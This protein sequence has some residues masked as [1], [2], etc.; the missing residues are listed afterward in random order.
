MSDLRSW[1]CRRPLRVHLQED[2]VLFFVHVP[3]T[4]GM[5]LISILESHFEPRHIFP[6]HSYVTEKQFLGYS[7]EQR[8]GYRLVR[9]HLRAGSY[10]SVFR[11][12]CQN[13]ICLTLLRDPVE[14][15]ISSYR[16]IVRHPRNPY[17]DEVTSRNL[18]LREYVEQFSSR[19]CNMQ[20][21]MIAGA[22][23]GNIELG[24]P[25]YGE[26][27]ALEI[28]VQRLEQFAFVGLTS[29]F[30]ESVELMCHTFGWTR[31]TEIPF[32][33][34]APEPTECGSVP[35]DVQ[36]IIRA[37]TELDRRL[38]EHAERLFERRCAQMMEERRADDGRH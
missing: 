16:H 1:T 28:A 34:A 32:E 21:W 29:W 12:I 15:T 37:K 20:T 14:R 30:V 23:T 33:N 8:A 19:V 38:L 26:E 36:E 27:A 25:A 3:K 5:S 22:V 31:P 6:G 2:D 11:H 7:P 24:A 9:M 4:G 10:G 17:H 13:P 18:S 35:P